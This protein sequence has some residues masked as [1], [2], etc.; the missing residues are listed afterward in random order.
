MPKVLEGAARLYDNYRRRFDAWQEAD[1][2][3]TP[4]VFIVVCNNT[5]VSKLVS[6]G[7]RPGT[8]ATAGRSWSGE[9]DAVHQCRRRGLV[10]TARARSC[11]LRPARVRRGMS[12]E[13]KK[14]AGA[15]STSSSA[16]TQRFPDRDLDEVTDAD[17][18]REVMNTVG[19]PGKLGERSAA[20]Q[21]LHADGGWDANTVT[22]ILGVRAF[23]TQLLCEQVVGAA[24]A[25]ARYAV[26]E[27]GLLHG[28]GVRR[29]RRRA[30][31]VHPHGRQA[32]QPT[33][34]RGPPRPLRA[35]RSRR[36]RDHLPAVDGLPGGDPREPALRRVR[37]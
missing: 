18:L 6:T 1:D 5:A 16:S 7:R 14:V 33:R 36:G 10:G 17:L 2:D 37:G 8:N 22:H 11:R 32:R 23:G 31:P 35:L 13:F 4:P 19:K 20:C 24:S 21:R 28:T 25:G 9:L 12:A 30:V 29:R 26:D 34:S 27:H 3:G 15:R